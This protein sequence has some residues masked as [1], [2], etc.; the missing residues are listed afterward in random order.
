MKVN[1]RKGG[2][3]MES[4]QKEASKETQRKY[5]VN[6]MKEVMAEKKDVSEKKAFLAKLKTI[7]DYHDISLEELEELEA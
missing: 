4:V 2:M 7:C 3:Y 5:I 6:W 1:P